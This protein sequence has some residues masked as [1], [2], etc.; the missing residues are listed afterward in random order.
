MSTVI[1]ESP[2]SDRLEEI[3]KQYPELTYISK[4]YDYISPEVQEKHRDI[5]EE[6]SKILND[7]VYGFREFNNFCHDKKGNLCVRCQTAWSPSFVGVS[8]FKVADMRN[9]ELQGDVEDAE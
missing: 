9:D 7:R 8:Y 5:I 4:G 2:H 1:S 3:Q 6:V